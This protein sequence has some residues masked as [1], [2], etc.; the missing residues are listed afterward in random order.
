MIRDKVLNYLY[1]SGF[2]QFYTKKLM[3]REDIND[4]YEDYVQEVWLQLCEIDEDKWKDLYNRRPNQ[5]EFYDVRNWTS[6]IIRNTVKSVTSAAY[7]KLKK[8]STVA[9]QLNDGEW[10][11]LSNVVPDTS[12]MF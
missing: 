3:Y 8:Q 2:V 7:R 9:K 5:D 12:A 4:L 11:Y 10:N 1:E 6:V